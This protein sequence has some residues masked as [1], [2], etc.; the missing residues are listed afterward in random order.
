MSKEKLLNLREFLKLCSA[1]YYYGDGTV[2]IVSDGVYDSLM[3]ELKELEEK[4]PELYDPKSPSQLVGG[5]AR[6]DA[7]KYLAQIKDRYGL[8]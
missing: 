8:R 6:E 7:T 5:I 4:Y 2:D 3:L 1:N